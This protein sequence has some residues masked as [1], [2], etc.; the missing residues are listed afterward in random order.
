VKAKMYDAIITLVDVEGDFSGRL[1]PKGT[2]GTVIE[3]YNDPQEGYAVD[4]AIPDPSLVGGSDYENVILYPDQF[5]V[6][7]EK[8]EKKAQGFGRG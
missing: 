5:T 6:L 2:R 1:I 8:D 3:C 7:D 4:L